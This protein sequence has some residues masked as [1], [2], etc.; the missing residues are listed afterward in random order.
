MNATLDYLGVCGVPAAPQA[1]FEIT[2]TLKAGEQLTFFNTS[3]GSPWMTYEWN[4]GDG[5]T[6]TLQDPYVKH[7]YASGGAYTVTLA[8]VN[9]FGQNVV[10][11]LLQIARVY[12]VYLP[13]VLK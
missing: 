7:S 10:S 5:V 6:S 4:F 9:G 8:A 12:Q 2:G 1:N 13:V 11:Q 3:H